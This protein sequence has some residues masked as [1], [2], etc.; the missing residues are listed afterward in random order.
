MS[1]MPKSDPIPTTTR[2]R[3]PC[4]VVPVRRPPKDWV[5]PDYDRPLLPEDKAKLDALVKELWGDDP[6]KYEK[7]IKRQSYMFLWIAGLE[8]EKRERKRAFLIK[9]GHL[10][11]SA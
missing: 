3:R 8:K 7:F 2:R 1:A 11:V 10:A 9:N 4:R 5:E 6:E